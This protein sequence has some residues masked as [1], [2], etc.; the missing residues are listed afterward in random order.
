M[1]TK[2]KAKTVIFCS[3]IAAVLAATILVLT[4]TP[5]L[6]LQEEDTEG[7]YQTFYINLYKLTKSQNILNHTIQ[8]YSHIGGNYDKLKPLFKDAYEIAETV[9][10]ET[11]E[12]NAFTKTDYFYF[13]LLLANGKTSEADAFVE[14]CIADG[15]I[16]KV[17]H[18]LYMMAISDSNAQ[19]RNWAVERLQMIVGSDAYK[20]ELNAHVPGDLANESVSI[21]SYLTEALFVNGKSDE[22]FCEIEKMAEFN[23][24]SSLIFVSVSSIADKNTTESKAFVEKAI[25]FAAE[26]GV[27]SQE[28]QE[29]LRETVKS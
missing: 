4:C 7:K 9:S 23:N 1:K 5:V 24:A 22:A 21:W 28:E 18:P 20:K 6:H 19:N 2:A 13:N 3:V 16:G 25:G 26:K 12:L 10:S 17:E 27:L 11:V 15:K 14:S 29:R 8:S